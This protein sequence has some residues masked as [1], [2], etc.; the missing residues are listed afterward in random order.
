MKLLNFFNEHNIPKNPLKLI[1]FF[2][3][4]FWFYKDSGASLTG[5]YVSLFTQIG[6]WGMIIK[7]LFG[8]E[9]LIVGKW[10]VILVLINIV[11]DF[12]VGIIYIFSGLW[13]YRLYLLGTTKD[14]NPVGWANMETLKRICKRLG[15]KD[16]FEEKWE[17]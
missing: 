8:V 7:V 15:I 12:V 13:K 1:F 2:H 14:K 3:E 6:M 16:A 5:R 4:R 11:S 17:E 10:L 9:L